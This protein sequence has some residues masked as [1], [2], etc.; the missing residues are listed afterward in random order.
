MYLASVVLSESNPFVA[1]YN[2]SK[3]LETV[4]VVC[5]ISCRYETYTEVSVRPSIEIEFRQKWYTL[6]Q[7][8]TVSQLTVSISDAKREE[9]I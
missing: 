7:V 2:D 4:T 8:V 1:T 3:N 9:I 5:S 6:R